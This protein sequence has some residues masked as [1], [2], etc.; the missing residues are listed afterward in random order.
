VQSGSF[1]A[2]ARMIVS[3]SDRSKAILTV[4]GGQSGDP[5]SPHFADRHAAWAAGTPS[6]LLP[7]PPTN[8]I[9]L[10]PTSP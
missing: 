7:G 4:P 3:P 9:D 1:G 10:V 5:R 8:V 6:P 2:S